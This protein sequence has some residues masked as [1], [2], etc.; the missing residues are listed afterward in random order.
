MPSLKISS[1]WIDS[2]E[3][4]RPEI[5]HS[6]GQLGINVDGTWL[7]EF[8]TESGA[9]G[10]RI[11]IPA[12]PLAEWI[13]ENWWSILYEPEK[14]ERSKSDPAFKARHWFGTAREG[15]ALPD[16]WM[17]SSGRGT[18]RLSADAS[19]FPF[20]RLAMRNTCDASIRTEDAERELTSFIDSVI[21]RLDQ[22]GVRDTNLHSIWSAFKHLDLDERRFCRLLGA[23][24]MSPYSASPDLAELLT[25]ILGGASES[26]TEDFCEAADEGDILDAAA[27]MVQT[28][29][30]L[31]TEPELDLTALFRLYSRVERTPKKAAVNAA[32]AARE[33]FRIEPYD[34]QG[35]EAF[36]S[37]LALQPIIYDREG[38]REIEEP[39]LHGSLRRQANQLQF[40]LIRKQVSARR[41]DAARACYLAWIQTSDGD[42]LVTRARVPDQQASRIF[43]AE[44]LAP[45]DY[46]RSRTRNNILSP[47][48]VAAI[49]DELKISGAIV[50][51]QAS[52]NGISAV[53]QHGGQWS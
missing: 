46:I 22:K 19:F 7:T 48:G 36:L 34:P 23:L 35:G 28:L 18:V 42:R 38:T 47:Y 40:N 41:F 21:D 43:A 10:E 27:D 24:G 52:H 11:E 12:F 20:A 14:G 31:E 9:H 37:S 50:S 17:H 13:A 44:I 53:G 39:V 5:D 2:E 4:F 29:R 32:R 51:W 1:E 16:A 26:V 6:Y 45:I 15:F 49:A 3:G 33:R 8:D 30:A 25:K